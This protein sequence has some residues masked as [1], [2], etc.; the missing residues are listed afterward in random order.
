MANEDELELSRDVPD[1]GMEDDE[2]EFTEFVYSTRHPDDWVISGPLNGGGPG[3]KF[4][5]WRAAADWARG[6]YGN[7]YKGPAFP[8]DD[9]ALRWGFLIRGPR[10]SK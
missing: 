7:K 5:S 6:F 9:G 10:G 2:V 8:P 4:D 3:R 1:I